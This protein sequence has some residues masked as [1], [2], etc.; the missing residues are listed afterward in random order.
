MREWCKCE[1]FFHTALFPTSPHTR[2][3]DQVMASQQG[4][5]WGGFPTGLET[6]QSQGLWGSGAGRWGGLSQ[7]N[8]QHTHPSSQPTH[9]RGAHVH[10]LSPSSTPAP[11]PRLPA[12][13][14]LL[15][16]AGLIVLR[17]DHVR[18][19]IRPP[20][21]HKQKTGGAAGVQQRERA[22][23][24]TGGVGVSE[25]E[26]LQQGERGEKGSGVVRLQPDALACYLSLV[27]DWHDTDP[28]FG[29]AADARCLPRVCLSESQPQPNPRVA[30][31]S[32]PALQQQQHSTQQTQN[33]S[34]LNPQQQQPHPSAPS[35]RQPQ[36]QPTP[37]HTPHLQQP[38]TS[39][40]AP[41]TAA[42]TPA[43]AAAPA[44]RQASRAAKSV[45]F[46]RADQ[47]APP[48]HQQGVGQGAWGEGNE[49]LNAPSQEPFA[50]GS[51]Q[52]VS[53]GQPHQQHPLLAAPPPS[54]QPSLTQQQPVD[55]PAQQ[56]SQQQQQ[57]VPRR[58]PA[59]QRKRKM[60]KPK[61]YSEG[62]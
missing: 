58:V 40:R 22:G 32:L 8:P 53:L 20:Q 31:P 47:Q 16:G 48:S 12:T 19:A 43:P 4:Q 15:Q 7:A 29:T 36:S 50:F 62:F 9:T 46:R 55:A 21:K 6:Q 13:T 17:P 3:G 52:S 61:T 44:T 26:R 41:G 5:A 59:V 28:H 37:Q 23:G 10:G 56:Q 54:L 45:T 1:S 24:E 2:A 38:H 30:N 39:N 60:G 34:L 49:G 42:L 11:P 57:Q 51:Q 14:A 33:P 25:R 35:L 18:P 27:D